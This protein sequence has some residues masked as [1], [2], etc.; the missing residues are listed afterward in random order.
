LLGISK[1]VT[2]VDPLNGTPFPNNVIPTSRLN[3]VSLKAQNAYLPVPNLGAAGSLV[4][5]FQWVHPYPGDQFVADVVAIRLDHRFSD[6]NSSTACSRL[7]LPRHVSAGTYPALALQLRQSHP[8]RSS[9]L[10]YPRQPS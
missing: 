2:I 5:N 10:T 7:I 9:I 8:G 3:A 6:K 1:P 4:N